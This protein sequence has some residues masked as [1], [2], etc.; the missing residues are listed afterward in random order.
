MSLSDWAATRKVRSEMIIVAAEKQSVV[1]LKLPMSP[2][3]PGHLPRGNIEVHLHWVTL[4][5]L[6]GVPCTPKAVSWREGK[7]PFPSASQ[8]LALR[9]PV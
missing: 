9:G 5:V 6:A 7:H 8:E 1:L 2:P 3:C 4:C